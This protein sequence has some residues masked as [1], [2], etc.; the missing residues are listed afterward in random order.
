MQASSSLSLAARGLMRRAIGPSMGRRNR[1]HG[2]KPG[3]VLIPVVIACLC[4]WAR[5]QTSPPDAVPKVVRYAFQ[6]DETNF[7]AAQVTD[8]YSRIVIAAM[9]EAPLECSKTPGSWACRI[10]GHGSSGKGCP[11]APSDRP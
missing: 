11:T 7:D 6:I 5:A 9:L 2:G 3:R 1:I 4:G 8:V 10:C